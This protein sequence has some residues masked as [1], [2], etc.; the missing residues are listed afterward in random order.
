MLVLECTSWIEVDDL[1]EIIVSV[2]YLALLKDLMKENN[3]FI[4][5]HFRYI[6][7]SKVLNKKRK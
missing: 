6:K 4:T 1:A 7:E 3:V 2:T 5:E